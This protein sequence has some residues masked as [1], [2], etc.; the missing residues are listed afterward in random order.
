MCIPHPLQLKACP[1]GLN[2]ICLLKE[3]LKWETKPK[4]FTRHHLLFLF[5]SH[6]VNRVRYSP[7]VT[8]CVQIYRKYAPCLRTNPAT[9]SSLILRRSQRSCRWNDSQV[10]WMSHR[11]MSTFSGIW[12]SYTRVRRA[13]DQN[14]YYVIFSR[15]HMTGSL[16]VV[17]SGEDGNNEIYL[18][19]CFNLPNKSHYN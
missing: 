19:L 18:C 6:G 13:D 17:I 4:R 15:L 11:T 14:M 10:L 1:C 7:L 2:L 5:S 12:R 16:T 8:Q 3:S 9:W